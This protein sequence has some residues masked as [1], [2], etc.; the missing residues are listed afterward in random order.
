MKTDRQFSVT[1]P[2][3]VAEAVESRIK[4]GAYSSVSEVLGAGV[5]ALIESDATLE[6]WLR[7]EVVAGHQAYLA[8]PSQGVR[9]DLVLDRIKA[10]RASQEES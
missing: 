3:D 9:A 10:R 8:D 2:T 7:E 5:R 4:S 6:N 1:L